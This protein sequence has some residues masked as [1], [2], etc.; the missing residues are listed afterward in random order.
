MPLNGSRD[1]QLGSK[2]EKL[3]IVI[4]NKRSSVVLSSYNSNKKLNY[5]WQTARRV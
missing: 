3:S 5:R 4:V 1:A 2:H